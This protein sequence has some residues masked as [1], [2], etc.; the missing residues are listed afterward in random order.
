MAKYDPL[1]AYLRRKKNAVLELSFA[2]IERVIGAML[3][4]SASAPQW[5]ED[6]GAERR[7]IQC[8]AW[9]DAGYDALLVKGRDRVIFRR[10][11][12]I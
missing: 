1:G 10:R 12:D 4:N 9:H 5:W 3:P 2:D 8:R 11:S 7:Q 6:E